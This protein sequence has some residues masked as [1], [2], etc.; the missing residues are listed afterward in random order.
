MLSMPA[1]TVLTQLAPTSMSS[2]INSRAVLQV[3]RL[4]VCFTP[5]DVSTPSRSL[6]LSPPSCSAHAM[7]SQSPS[8]AGNSGGV[9]DKKS[10]STTASISGDESPGD[11]AA[12]SGEG[13]EGGVSVDGKGAGTETKEGST[14]GSA[15]TASSSATATAA[16]ASGDAPAAQASTSTST[17]AAE[18]EAS[19]SRWG[20]KKSFLDVSHV[21]E[22]ESESL[23]PLESSRIELPPLALVAPSSES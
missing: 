11:S 4:L 13:S 5:V 10:P 16:P 15:E 22:S 14:S 18:D 3:L 8:A 19:G 20:G 9:E 7:C 21:T 2:N 1:R 12:A 17:A 6:T 23:S